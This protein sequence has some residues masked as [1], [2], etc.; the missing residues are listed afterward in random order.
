MKS[1]FE[2]YCTYELRNDVISTVTPADGKDASTSKEATAIGT[3]EKIK[4][5]EPVYSMP[6]ENYKISKYGIYGN[7]Q[8]VK[9]A[10]NISS[11][12]LDRLINGNSLPGLTYH[13]DANAHAYI[14]T[15]EDGADGTEQDAI[16]GKFGKK[17][18]TYSLVDSEI[19]LEDSQNPL[20]KDDYTFTSLEYSVKMQDAAYNSE[21]KNFNVQNVTEYKESDILTFYVMKG[22]DGTYKKA[23]A[24]NLS[25]SKAD[26]VDSSSISSL[27]G[28]SVTFKEGVN[29]WKIETSNPYYSIYFN[30]Y[31]TIKL[32]P[33]D[34]VRNA[35]PATDNAKISVKN[36]STLNVVDSSQTSITR[37]A[38]GT[39][40]AAKVKI[41]SNIS[42]KVV[43][44]KN[45][46]GIRGYKIN[47]ETS[48]SETYTDDSGKYP[49]RQESG[50]FYDLIPL[51]CR[52]DLSSIKVFAD[53][54]ELLES[55]Y[56]IDDPEENYKN[57]NRTLLI[58]RINTPA[59]KNYSMTYTT[60]H[61]WE[62][63][64]DYGRFV[65]NSVAY[66][67][68]NPDI[69]GSYPDNGGSISD[70]T[71]LTDLDLETNDKRF[72]YSQAT[73]IY[74]KISII[75]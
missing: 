44:A 23:A 59:E 24:Y 47:W 22:D 63:V 25:T 62:D 45:Y 17:N 13:I 12:N 6:G 40:Y 29:G 61:L 27:T 33:T 32:N 36:I 21:S 31:P 28:S 26:I 68:G 19:Y 4:P 50:V 56:T 65:L 16:D 1:A 42:K 55:E 37:S 18:V 11:Y 3:Y 38:S 67:T 20:S 35:I 49:V 72:I 5:P 15:L 70:S 66:E 71:I 57:S 48:M 2:D 52:A 53:G 34:A 74:W 30:V 14:K 51:G 64:L 54:A 7:K 73:S 9:S 60:V 8:H 69:A 75:K 46:P 41:N 43:S 39:D 10:N 58:V